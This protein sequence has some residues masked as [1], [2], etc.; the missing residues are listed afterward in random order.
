MAA[1]AYRLL[2][3]GELD[4]ALVLHTA[5]PPG[6][7]E[8]KALVE[9]YR[10]LADT[11]SGLSGLRV[12]V[13]TDGGGPNAA[14][15]S[16]VNDVFR[17]QPKVAVVT[18]SALIRGIITVFAW[19]NPATTGFAPGEL[20]RALRHLELPPDVLPELLRA[21]TALEQV[22]GTVACL[23]DAQAQ[24]SATSGTTAA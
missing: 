5:A 13:L 11:N 18:A 10:R 23:R 21:L 7:D 3:I 14:Q 19:F 6:Y 15:R 1:M 9:E 22:T 2:R 20:D 24:R 17:G 12:L 4:L 16:M 8:W